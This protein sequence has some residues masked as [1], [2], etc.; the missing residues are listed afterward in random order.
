MPCISERQLAHLVEQERAAVG[1]LDLAAH[2][3]LGAGE[4][5]ALVAEELALDE[6]PRQRRAVDRHEGPGLARRVD[7]DRAGEQVLAG[8]GRA[9][10]QH[11]RVGLGGEGDALVDRAPSAALRPTMWLKGPRSTRPGPD[12][13]SARSVVSDRAAGELRRERD[14]VALVLGVEGARARG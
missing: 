6:L 10:Q 12:A 1:H 8:A 4:G 11:R 7:V 2:A 13:S 9:A 5:A 14:E 3:S